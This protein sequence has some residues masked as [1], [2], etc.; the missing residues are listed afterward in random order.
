M[1]IV[2]SASRRLAA[3]VLALIAQSAFGESRGTAPVPTD[4]CPSARFGSPALVRLGDDLLTTVVGD[5]CGVASLLDGRSGAARRRFDDP[6][7]G[8]FHL[9][10]GIGFGA[11]I[12][13]AGRRLLVSAPNDRVV[14]AFDARS[15]NEVRRYVGTGLGHD[16]FGRNLLGIGKRVV[17]GALFTGY[18]GPDV[19]TYGAIYVFDA[20]SDSLERTITAPEDSHATG[21]GDSL[22]ALSRDRVVVGTIDDA[23]GTQG[24]VFVADLRDGSVPLTILPPTP[25]GIDSYALD[26]TATGDVIVVGV[27]RIVGPTPTGTVYLYDARS[28]ELRRTIESP[29]A[30]GEAFGRWPVIRG[31]TL[32][33]AAPSGVDVSVPGSLYVIDVKTGRTRARLVLG[34]DVPADSVL[35]PLFFR[36]GLA[37][38]V[39]PDATSGE[40]LRVE[41]GYRLPRRP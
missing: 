27:A 20:A 12:G 9:E 30:P 13:V 28:G 26:F 21:F 10:S 3:T 36:R 41:Y 23:Q 32:V 38:A 33:V 14:Y 24:K 29:A 17:V 15:G 11:A 5:D 7:R 34:A 6:Q 1:R 19:S 16:G 35:P 8:V 31:R 39:Q 18:V 37:F 2:R 40:A 4:A 22:A 25:N